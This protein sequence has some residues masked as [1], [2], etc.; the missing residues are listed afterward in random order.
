MSEV[1]GMLKSPMV[2]IGGGALGLVL[3]MTKGSTVSGSASAAAG[4]MTPA[5]MSASVSMNAA[6][7]GAQ[8]D[9]ARVQADLGKAKLA[10]DVTSESLYYGYLKNQADNNSMLAGKQI[11]SNAGITTAII[12]SG[13]A[14]QL[15][16][17]GNANRLALAYVDSNKSM[18][19]TN[20]NVEIARLQAN[21]QKSVAKSSMIGN[22][23][24]SVAKVATAFA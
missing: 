13:T 16:Q 12:A 10:A 2:W 14:I 1:G 5:Y 15:D 22:I 17:Q 24:G 11:E 4:A 8:I 20:G 9:L 3:L 6:A 21:A 7:L 23:F 19:T 18:Y